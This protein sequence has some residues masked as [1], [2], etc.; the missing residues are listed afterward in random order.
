MKSS[1]DPSND[2]TISV[3][4]IPLENFGTNLIYRDIEEYDSLSKVR[5][6]IER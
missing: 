5:A 4:S 2:D 3:Q 1:T 6:V